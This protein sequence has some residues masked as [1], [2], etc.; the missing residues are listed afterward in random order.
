M[1]CVQCEKIEVSE[2]FTRCSACETTHKKLCAELDARP[3]KQVEKV[4]EVLIPFKSVKQGIEVTT[5]MTKEEAQIWRL[6]IP[7]GYE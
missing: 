6:K 7:S 2:E 3:K 1:N 5:W 4:K